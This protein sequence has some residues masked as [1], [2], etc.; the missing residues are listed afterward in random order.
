MKL[1]ALADK[2]PLE[3]DVFNRTYFESML[4]S[5]SLGYVVPGDVL[6]IGGLPKYRDVV[7]RTNITSSG[8]MPMVGFA[9]ATTTRPLNDY[10]D[11]QILSKAYADAY[12]LIFAR[13]MVDV[14]DRNFTSSKEISGTK[15][16]SSQALVLEPIFVH[17]VVGLL[18][19]VSV[20]TAV[21]LYL[22]LSRKRYLHTDPSTLASIMPMVADDQSLL[23]DFAD[24]DCCTLEDVQN[25]IG[26][27]RYKLEENGA[28]S[29]YVVVLQTRCVRSDQCQHSGHYP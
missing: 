26:Q 9:L 27:R 12:R 23:A 5:G 13:A 21:L 20:A 16:V 3:W 7:S 8:M 11:W 18:A 22:S 17:I 14:L 29:R 6:P 2:Q 10:L 19:V 25:A 15:T 1:E 24:L 28:G 4:N